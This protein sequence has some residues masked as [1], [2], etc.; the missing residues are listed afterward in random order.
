[1]RTVVIA[2]GTRGIGGALAARLRQ[3]GDQVLAL[4]SEDADLTSV[5]QTTE[6][7]SRLPDRI[8][9]LVLAAGRFDQR[10]V[11]TAE[12]LEQTFAIGVLSRYLLTEGLRPALAKAASTPVVLNL[13]GTGGIRA[14]RIHWD[15]LQLRH[16]YTMFKATMQGARANDLLGVAFAA[17]ESRIRYV[18]YN[19]LLVN[20]GMHRQL[21]QPL[22]TLV[23]AAAATF[24]TTV[25]NAAEPLAGLLADPPDAPLTALRR[26]KPVSLDRSE[27]DPGTAERLEAVLTDL[28]ARV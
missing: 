4:G 22:R 12:G 6:L 13:S 11:V 8:D 25:D 26:G 9:A 5:R 24:G 14:G 20:S 1:M 16:G 17:R 15:D 27:F 7:I 23:G 2:G 28:A 21:R 19:P 3:A 10:R 18:L